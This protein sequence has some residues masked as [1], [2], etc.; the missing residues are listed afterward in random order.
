MSRFLA[1]DYGKKRLGLALSDET[2]S[3]AFAQ[4]YILTADWDKLLKFIKTKEVEKILVGLPKSLS[5]AEGAA[6]IAARQFGERLA[7]ATGLGVQFIDE[8][9]STREATS[10]LHEAETK[11]R[12]LRQRVDSAS[13]QLLLETYLRRR[14]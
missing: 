1:I 7:E 5:G 11:A 14:T 12:Q 9:F 10:R 8:R 4:P 2:K 6:A 3:L 13:A